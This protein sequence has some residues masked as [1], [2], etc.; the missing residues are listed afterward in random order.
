MQILTDIS[1]SD[2][3]HFTDRCL[4]AICCNSDQ[5]ITWPEEDKRDDIKLRIE[6]VWEIPGCLG[7]IDGIHVNLEDA[8][9]KPNKGATRFWSYKKKYGMLLLAICDHKKRLRFVHWGYSAR[10]S[11]MKAQQDS[12]LHNSVEELFRPGKWILGDSGLLLTEHVIPMFKKRGR[13]AKL[14][15]REVRKDSI[16]IDLKRV[17][18]V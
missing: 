1:A 5:Y 7:F 4:R 13:N 9:E 15:P 16:L 6:E 18:W 3:C 10:S 12:R 11:D 2:V 14:A 17:L 8:P